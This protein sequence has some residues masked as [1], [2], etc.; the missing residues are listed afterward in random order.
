MKFYI[1]TTFSLNTSKGDVTIRLSKHL[2]KVREK[3]NESRF[4]SFMFQS[5]WQYEDIIKAA[6]EQYD[7]DSFVNKGKVALI[8][9]FN[10]KEFGMLLDV[11]KDNN[12]GFD[13]TIITIDSLRDRH[14]SHG[15]MFA[16]ENNKIYTK[17]QLKNSFLLQANIRFDTS[18]Q[19]QFLQTQFFAD[20]VEKYK[21]NAK[22]DFIRVFHS[23]LTRSR[24]E[25]L[26]VNTSFWIKIKI[27]S[28]EHCYIRV[29]IEEVKV[30]ESTKMV[31]IMS[32]IAIN[33]GFVQDRA[34]LKNEKIIEIASL[35]SEHF[36]KIKPLA[37]PKQNGLRIKKKGT[38][39]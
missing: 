34:L 31:I 5:R 36:G 26:D 38:T 23:L 7:I 35:T 28:D 25:S 17:Y 4:R 3:N 32:D 24:A 8:F 18:G 9:Y 13:V 14:Y 12:N 19:T 33:E 20:K 21:Y 1:D 6:F 22:V 30:G 10:N 27:T 29:S 15:G 39:I 11:V 2:F 37:R 16:R